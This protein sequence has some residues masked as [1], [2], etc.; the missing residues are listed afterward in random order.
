M[1]VVKNTSTM[2]NTVESLLMKRYGTKAAFGRVPSLFTKNLKSL[3][4]LAYQGQVAARMGLITTCYLQQASGNLLDNLTSDSPNL[5]SAIQNVRDIFAL[6]TKSLD[7][8][9]RTGAFHHMI[10]RRATMYDTGLNELRAYAITIVTLPLT[11]D[12]N[13]GSQF[14]TKMKEKTD[15]NKQLA[16]VLPDNRRVTLGSQLGKR[17]PTA[18]VTSESTFV[19]KPKFDSN[20]KIPKKNFGE[21][22]SSGK[23]TQATKPWE[24]ESITD[25]QWVLKTLQEGLKLEFQETPHLTGI[26]HTSVNAK[27]LPIILAEVEDLIEKKCNRDCTSSRDTS[28]FLQYTFSGSQEN[29]RFKTC[30]KLETSQPVSEEA[31]FQNGH[32]NKSFESSK[33]P[34]LGV[35]SRSERCISPY[36]SSQNTQKISTFLHTRQM[37]PICSSVFRSFSSTSSVHKN[38]Y[39]SSSSSENPKHTPSNLFGRLVAS[40]CSRENANFRQR[41]NTQSSDKTGIYSK[42]SKIFSYPITRD[43]LHRGIVQF[44]EGDSF[45]NYRKEF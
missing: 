9:A 31:T 27:N 42:S 16:E 19:K 34:R 26:K 39:C 29:R 43:H 3:E 7:Q 30:D 12:G 10:R 36:S 2:D 25:D 11:A 13:F 5:D 41:E 18:T 28:R 6:S 23:Q 44:Q 21:F 14:D 32:F 1:Q 35:V 8:T 22:K 17:K 4:R 37:L 24:W 33:T 38:S 45:S 20:F 40:E 15:R